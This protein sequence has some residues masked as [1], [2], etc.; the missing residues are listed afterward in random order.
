M[1]LSTKSDG[2]FGWGWLQNDFTLSYNFLPNPQYPISL[3]N[4][5]RIGEDLNPFL[6][7]SCWERSENDQIRRIF[8]FLSYSS[9]RRRLQF[10][11]P[12]LLWLENSFF[13]VLLDFLPNTHDLGEE[14]RIDLIFYQ[15]CW[16]ISLRYRKGAKSF[17]SNF[18][19]V[20]VVGGIWNRIR[21]IGL[22]GCKISLSNNLDIID[23]NLEDLVGFGIIITSA[24]LHCI[25]TSWKHSAPLKRC[26]T[27]IMQLF[28]YL[29]GY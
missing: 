12:V 2:S 15:I 25:D 11:L 13:I 5:H 20:K 16:I 29:Y 9:Y 23:D 4:V 19:F 14:R 18:A 3:N 17:S 8:P 22:R 10:F 28:E 6:P 7:S 27:F 24:L 26:V 21:M 1:R